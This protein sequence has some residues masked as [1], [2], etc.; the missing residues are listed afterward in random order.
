MSF[1]LESSQAR[2]VLVPI[3]ALRISLSLINESW[4]FTT[5]EATRSGTVGVDTSAVD[6]P[7]LENGRALQRANERRNVDSIVCLTDVP[8]TRKLFSNA[9]GHGRFPF[10]AAIYYR[11]CRPS[12]LNSIVELEIA[13]KFKKC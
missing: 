8:N 11:R 12:R 5:P 13:K 3:A 9:P 2:V 6:T 7:R 1:V 4:L 10:A